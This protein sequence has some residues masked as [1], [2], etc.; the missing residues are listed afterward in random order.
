MFSSETIFIPIDKVSSV[1]DYLLER[2]GEYW[3]ELYGY[4]TV[5]LILI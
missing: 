5:E 4:V 2:L 3:K 1:M